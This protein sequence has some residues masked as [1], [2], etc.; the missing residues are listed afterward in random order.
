MMRVCILPA[1]MATPETGMS[2]VMYV[3]LEEVFMNNIFSNH[4]RFP[5]NNLT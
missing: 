3:Y 5:C 4:S 2:S 1:A